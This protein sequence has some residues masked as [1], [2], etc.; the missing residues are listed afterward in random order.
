M[1]KCLPYV[2]LVLVVSVIITGCTP[3]VQKLKL[4][5]EKKQKLDELVE[6]NDYV[7][8]YNFDKYDYPAI[9]TDY[10]KII[11][12]IKE[13]DTKKINQMLE[14][15]DAIGKQVSDLGYPEFVFSAQ[16]EGVLRQFALYE[17]GA[18]FFNEEWLELGVRVRKGDL[19]IQNT[20]VDES[21]YYPAII[22]LIY[23]AG[24]KDLNSVYIEFNLKNEQGSVI[25]FVND[26]IGSLKKGENWQFRCDAVQEASSYEL[27]KLTYY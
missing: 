5:E 8:G 27:S 17:M 2:I 22:G 4:S 19:V 23:N 15:L 21:G 12:A 14:D 13:Q 10:T 20:Q 24:S 11:E 26:G 1:K 7:T 18:T 6:S 3:E 9:I 25:G 16:E